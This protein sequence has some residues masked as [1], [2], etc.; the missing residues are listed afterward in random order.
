M[1]HLSLPTFWQVSFIVD[2]QSFFISKTKHLFG[3]RRIVVDILLS[4]CDSDYKSQLQCD[5]TLTLKY[6]AKSM[7]NNIIIVLL[8]RLFRGWFKNVSNLLCSATIPNPTAAGPSTT[9]LINETINLDSSS[10]Q[11]SGIDSTTG[12]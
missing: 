9:Q 11:L 10:S 7:S 1:L 4:F 6:Q 2:Y 12:H 5:S 3:G 8:C